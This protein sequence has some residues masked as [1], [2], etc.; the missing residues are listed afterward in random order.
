MKLTIEK[1]TRRIDDSSLEILNPFGVSATLIANASVPVELE[2][3]KELMGV[4][5][6]QKTLEEIAHAEA[7]DRCSFWGKEGAD[8]Q[9]G[10]IAR[11]VVT[12]D[13]HKGSGIPIGTVIDA[14]NFVIPKAVGNDVC[15]GMRLIVTDLPADELKQHLDQFGRRLRGIFFGG[16]RNIPM[17]PQQ[18]EGLL[19][20][21]LQGLHEHALTNINTGLWKYYDRDQE[22]DNLKFTHLKGCLPVV[23]DLHTFDDFVEGSGAS[24]GRDA[25]IGSVGG[26]NHF[27][28]VQSVDEIIDGTTAHHWGI[29]KGMTAVMIHSGSV[30]LGHSVG[31][32]FTRLAKNLFPAGLAHPDHGFYVL[33][34]TGPHAQ[35]LQDYINAMNMVANFAFG[36]RLCLGL[37]AIRALSEA[38]GRPIAHRLIYDAP[39]N[40]IWRDGNRFIHRKGAC[41]ALGAHHLLQEEP[42][43]FFG[44]PVIIPGSMGASSFLLAGKGNDNLLS[45]ACH[46][47]G[48]SLTRTAARQ[49]SHQKYS[50][51]VERL[52]VITPID[53]SLPEIAARPDVLA[54]YH[55][56]LME[57][58]PYAYKP[59]TPVI[60][61]VEQAG[62]ASRVARL[63]PILTVKG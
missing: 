27:V 49:V 46:G 34:A 20:R 39:H 14:R 54:K 42:F 23:G 40:L 50:E 61:S 1:L 51:V 22:L 4:L 36:N 47:A 56:R 7:L 63:R 30:G 26:G 33:P 37:M 2:G 55:S 12:P 10:S 60:E 58:A 18:R 6:L 52:R 57:E 41:P 38:L 43:A 29:K 16:E 11:V 8:L 9:K 25:Q 28:E 13:F 48:R 32:H 3:L 17:S 31:G 45:S 62:I 24:D 21:G 35:H 59:I 44:I 53:P 5:S 15:C 19:R